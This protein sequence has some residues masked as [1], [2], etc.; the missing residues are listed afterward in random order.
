MTR[1]LGGD[2]TALLLQGY[3]YA[4]VI[5]PPTPTP[6]IPTPEVIPELKPRIFYEDAT[7]LLPLAELGI[8]KKFSGQV[9]LGR[10]S[11]VKLD[12]INA[13]IKELKIIL[14][15]EFQTFLTKL[16]IIGKSGMKISIKKMDSFIREDKKVFYI[17]VQSIISKIKEYTEA[18]E[19]LEILE[20]LDE[21]DD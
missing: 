10:L 19:I 15:V 5:I 3:G 17:D 21:L 9:H 20:T 16:S 18:K 7:V 12:K 11:I 4:I 13:L 14:P 6:P 1:G 8:V 2:E